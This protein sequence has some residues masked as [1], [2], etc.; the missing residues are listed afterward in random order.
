V[1]DVDAPGRLVH[2][3]VIEA[4]RA[5]VLGQHDVSELPQRHG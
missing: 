3:G 5:R 4:A 2:G 1:R